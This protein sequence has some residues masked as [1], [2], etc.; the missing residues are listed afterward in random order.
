MKIVNRFDEE[1]DYFDDEVNIK[2]EIIINKT[3]ENQT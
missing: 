3:S 1:D 2:D